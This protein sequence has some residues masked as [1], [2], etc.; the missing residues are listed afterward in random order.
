MKERTVFMKKSAPNDN[1]QKRI[2]AKN[3]NFY[4]SKSNKQQNE[5]A[6][7]LGFPPTTFNTWCVGKVMPKMGKVQAL[8]DYFGVLKSDLLEDKN[9]DDSLHIS[10]I[11]PIT[12]HKLPMLGEIAC[13]KPI[14]MDEN[15]DNYTMIG[16]NVKADFCLKAK[17][18]SMVNARIMDGD[19]VFIRS[20]PEV[21][22]GEI[23]AVAIDDEATLK[24]FY[25]D[26]ITQTVTLISENPIYA[27]MVF[28]KECQKN[29]YILGKAVAFQSDVK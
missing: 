23:A 22:N 8:A 18:D 17:G 24:R 20:Q 1:L 21:E 13:G 4:I 27:P 25:R 28:T 2:F 12:T 16:S 29:V 26:E 15:R 7:D 19:I 14:F 6:K 5:V 10:N 3:L 11:F 9:K